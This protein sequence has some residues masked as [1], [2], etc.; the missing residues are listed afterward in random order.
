MIVHGLHYLRSGV[1]A[2]DS[3]RRHCAGKQ[4]ASRCG[5]GAGVRRMRGPGWLESIGEPAIPPRIAQAR[6]PVVVQRR[7]AGC[8]RRRGMLCRKSPRPPRV[9]VRVRSNGVLVN[10]P[11]ERTTPQTTDVS[12]IRGE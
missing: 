10:R 7:S 3:E 9:G 4:T 2:R 8:H 12:H 1:P 11:T 6:P 5:G